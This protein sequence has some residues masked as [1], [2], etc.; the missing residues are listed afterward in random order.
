MMKTGNRMI[1]LVISILSIS[2]PAFAQQ[3]ASSKTP[4]LFKSEQTSIK[5]PLE[6][7]DPFKRKKM[8]SKMDSRQSLQLGRDGVYTNL[9]QIDGNPLES[10]RI[11]G[12][13]LGKE[14]RAIAKVSNNGA[15]SS[16]SY[17]LK[18]GMKLGENEAEIKAILPGGIVLV[19]KIRNVY[20]QD[21]YIETVIPITNAGENE[22]K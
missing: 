20:D 12:I 6:L 19:E 16:E 17:V 21:E 14:R 11:T 3:A 4:E 13:M 7:R 5:N 22:P 9:P 2:I 15:L 10:I 1:F 8:R 18:E